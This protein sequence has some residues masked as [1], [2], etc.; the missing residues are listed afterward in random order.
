M[1]ENEDQQVLEG[2]DSP[3]DKLTAEIS[4]Q[5]ED[6]SLLDA[7]LGLGEQEEGTDDPES[8]LNLLDESESADAVQIEDPVS[9]SALFYL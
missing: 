8:G 3:E 4:E 2:G 9:D 7:A 5:D 1:S 6:S